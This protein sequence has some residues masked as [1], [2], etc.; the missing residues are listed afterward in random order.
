MNHVWK[1]QLILCENSQQ[2]WFKITFHYLIKIKNTL[3][4]YK[5][6]VLFSTDL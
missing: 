1:E 3:F 2:I 5:A 6:S 4:H